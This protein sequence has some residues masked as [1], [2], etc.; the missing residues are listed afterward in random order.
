MAT[1]GLKEAV[2]VLLAQVMLVVGGSNN[3]FARLPT[4]MEMLPTIILVI[5]GSQRKTTA[6]KTGQKRWKQ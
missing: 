4:T 5:K 1:E 6:A 2:L 3:S